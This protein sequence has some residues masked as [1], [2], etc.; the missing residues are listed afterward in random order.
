M[1]ITEEPGPPQSM[2]LQLQE[3]PWDLLQAWQQEQGL[4]EQD[5]EWEEGMHQNMCF[6]V[7]LPPQ[8]SREPS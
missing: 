3:M 8:L 7:S 2:Q 5:E 1:T 6:G 4:E